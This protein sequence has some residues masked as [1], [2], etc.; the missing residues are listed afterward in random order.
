MLETQVSPPLAPELIGDRPFMFRETLLQALERWVLGTIWALNPRRIGG[1]PTL[2]RMWLADLVDR[3]AGLPDPEC[4]LDKPNGLAGIVHD[5]SVP[6]LVEA[7]RRGLF[8]FAHVAPLKWWSPPER[9]VLF[10]DEFRLGKHVRRLL[11]QGR[12]TVTFDRD[13]EGVIAACAGR[14]Q[15]KWHVTW[16]TPKIMHAYADLYDAG[17]VHSFE[18]WNQAGALVGG[19]YG[20]ALGRVFF[21]ESQFFREPNTSKLGFTV[22]N[23]HLARWGYRLNDGK[24]SAPTILDMGFRTIP[25]RRFLDEI[26]GAVRAAGKDGR[27]RVETDL[28]TI[29]AWEPGRDIREPAPES[30]SA[31]AHACGASRG[32]P[33][34]RAAAG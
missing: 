26:A 32:R 25:R 12:Y 13:F 16:I 3:Q 23:W 8:P 19:G 28:K 30:L 15:G 9:C 31:P 27:W 1:L 14:R 2:G 22:L 29:A 10:F 20:V 4:A 17:H 6:T 24:R 7:Y 21:T 33:S 18:V 11:R 34:R 5:L